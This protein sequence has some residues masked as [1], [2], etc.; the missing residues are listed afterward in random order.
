MTLRHR[1]QTERP[2]FTLVEMLVAMALI[3]FIMVILSEAFV[4]GLES[5]RQLKAIG[6][7]EERLR[8]ASVEIRRDLSA[9]HFEG[10]R[11]LSDPNF[12]DIPLREG[13]F[14]IVQNSLV[15]PTGPPIITCIFR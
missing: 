5:F 3:L 4:A 9:D 12:W 1:P 11:R 6:D 8:T 2:A 13:F 15:S 7:M 10:K 14:R